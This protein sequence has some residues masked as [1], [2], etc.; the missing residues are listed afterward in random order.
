MWHDRIH[1]DSPLQIHGL[2]RGLGLLLD[3][4]PDGVA[5]IPFTD[6]EAQRATTYEVGTRGRRPD[7]T[8]DVAA[9][10][11]EIDNELEPRSAWRLR[12]LS[13]SSERRL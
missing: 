11:A 1:G 5:A 8:W 2:L 12:S 7:V 6:I 4:P 10:R 13:L 9:Y 3:V